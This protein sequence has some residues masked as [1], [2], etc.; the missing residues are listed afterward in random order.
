MRITE[1]SI[2]LGETVNLGNYSNFRPEIGA[3]AEVEIW[4]NP[5]VVFA[6]L[7][8]NLQTQLADLIDEALEMAEMEPKYA[9]N[10]FGIRINRPR[11]VV[12]VVKKGLD[13]P[14][15]KTWR[16]RDNWQREPGLSHFIR[17]DTAMP[18]AEKIEASQ[19]LELFLIESLDD[20][21]ELP[22][23]PDPGPEPLWSQKELKPML[24]RLEVPE[25]DWEL[26]AG[27]PHVTAE[28]LRGFY[29]HTQWLRYGTEMKQT[30]LAGP[31]AAAILVQDDLVDEEE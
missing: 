2:K 28:Y 17:A 3:K 26:L 23:L 1:I 13:L 19:G 9:T 20:V 25:D 31:D 6:R 16:D 29:R 27:L 21:A 11:G 30:I 4:E 22:A 14:V 24:E 15:E 7:A 8:A 5:R 10:L 12:V 18:A